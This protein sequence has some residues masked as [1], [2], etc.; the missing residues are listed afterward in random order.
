MSTEQPYDFSE[1]LAMSQQATVN[2]R[3]ARIL[4]AEIPG[5]QKAVQA[6]NRDDRKGTDWWVECGSGYRISVDAKVRKEDWAAKPCSCDD[7]ALE[8]WSDVERKVV[9]WTRDTSKRTDYILWFWLDTNRWC[10]M[11]FR[12]LCRVFTEFWQTWPNLHQT[13]QQDSVEDG[14]TWKSECV[15]VPRREVW[16]QIYIRFAGDRLNQR[17]LSDGHSDG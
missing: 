12:L 6:S 11:P 16:L 17:P 5:A 1:Q 4:L 3:I 13:A 14:N 15:F 8:T 10:L 2:D 7:L 9:G